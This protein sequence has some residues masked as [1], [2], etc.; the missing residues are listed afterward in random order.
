MVA[1]CPGPSV[2]RPVR[3]CEPSS[4][5]QLPIHRV[6][7]ELLT[8]VTVCGFVAA[9]AWLGTVRAVATTSSVPN[10]VM[11]CRRKR[12]TVGLLEKTPTLNQKNARSEDWKKNRLHM[13]GDPVR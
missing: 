1:D 12:F 5:F 8:K 10:A 3:F 4:F 2:G 7:P 11:R 13:V 6:W 9:P